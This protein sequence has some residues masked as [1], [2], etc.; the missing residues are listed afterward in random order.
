MSA[1]LTKQQRQQKQQKQQKHQKSST[2]GKFR[3]VFSFAALQQIYTLAKA[4]YIQSSS[5]LSLEILGIVAPFLTKIEIGTINPAYVLVDQE[6]KLSK[7]E[8]LLIS[9]GAS[10]AEEKHKNNEIQMRSSKEI[11]WEECW[12]KFNENPESCSILEI[13][14]AKEHAYLNDLMSQEE[15]EEFEKKD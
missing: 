13:K 8:K 11:Y 10:L 3:P 2:R 12:K 15:I 5:P 14:A 4:D 1:N 6:G 9:L 7:E